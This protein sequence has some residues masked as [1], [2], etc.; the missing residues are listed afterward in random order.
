MQANDTIRVW[1]PLVRMFHWGTVALFTIAYLIEEPMI[2]H[3]WAGYGILA[4]LAMRL[5]WGLVGTRH[6]RFSDFVR[7]P[8]Q[9]FAYLRDA[10]AGRSRRHIG[11]NPAG[12]AMAVL[13]MALLLAIGGTGLVV[14]GAEEASGPLAGALAG[15][16]EWVEDVSEELHELLANFTLLCVFAHVAG[17]IFSSLQH[18]ENLVRSMLNGRKRGEESGQ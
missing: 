15:S 8:R 13:L 9:V 1:D 16:P 14:Y 18:G 3:A 12:G 17:V 11:H 7:P 6:A 2:V 10:L 4:L 5:V